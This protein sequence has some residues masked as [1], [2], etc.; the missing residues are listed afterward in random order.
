MFRALKPQ[1]LRNIFTRRYSSI[2]FDERPFPFSRFEPCCPEAAE[3]TAANG[4][5]PCKVH[6]FPEVI[7]RK[8][9][10]EADMTKLKGTNSHMVVCVGENG[11]EWHKAKVEKV[12][13]GM[14]EAIEDAKKEAQAFS[15][16][17]SHMPAGSNTLLTICDRERIQDNELNVPWPASDILLFPS[18]QVAK[19]VD[20]SN[21]QFKSLLQSAWSSEEQNL[22]SV[23]PYIKVEDLKSTTQ[24]VVLVCTH[25]MRDARCGVLGP[26]LIEE[27]K[28]SLKEKGL[29]GEE[30]KKSGK[31]VDVFGTSHFGG[32][33]DSSDRLFVLI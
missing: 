33:P 28:R 23:Q 20:P 5:R 22:K 1:A 16:R 25:R 6:P 31:H 29:H 3:K 17:E 19:A 9:D 13:L 12:R 32:K 8:V 21:P 14:V 30:A 26:L 10:F 18:F 4:F 11:P 2:P 24:A 15:S 27:L 7:G